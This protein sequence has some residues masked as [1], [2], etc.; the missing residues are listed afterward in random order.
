MRVVV[1]VTMV[2]LSVFAG[3]NG[4]GK[5][6]AVLGKPKTLLTVD[7]Q[8]GQ[9]LQYKFVSNRELEVDWDPTGR[10][11]PSG[12]HT[13][14]KVSESMELVMSYTPVELKPY[15]LTTIKATCDSAKVTRSKGTAR[16]GAMKDAVEALAGKSFVFTVGPT[17]K[18]EDYSQLEKLLS[19]IGNEAFQ[20]D[21]SRGRIKEPDMISDFI[22]TQW[23]LWDSVSS[24]EETARGVTTGQSWKSKLSIPAPMPVM[25]R[26]ARDVTYTLDQVRAGDK[27]RLAVIRSKYSPAESAPR[28]WPLPYSGSFQ[29]AGTF[30]FLRGYKIIDLQ[31]Q[32]EELFNIDSGRTERY[33]QQYKAQLE[34]SLPIGIGANPRVNINQTLTMELLK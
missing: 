21:T 10:T 6:K 11:S 34:T 27:G 2:F 23:F 22:A 16:R 8:E 17:G 1:I 7:F 13:A 25:L 20:S 33:S 12:K 24:I 14:D 29:M 5:G 30:G 3:C 26:R 32:G 9:T 31:G 18:I 28:S 19:E 4:A 15:G